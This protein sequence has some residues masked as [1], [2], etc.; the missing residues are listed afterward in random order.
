MSCSEELASNG[1]IFTIFY[2]ASARDATQIASEKIEIPNTGVSSD[3]QFSLSL[4]DLTM[5]LSL[6]HPALVPVLQ[7]SLYAVNMEY[8]DKEDKAFRVKPGDEVAVIP[9]VSGG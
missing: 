5:L 8:V 9:P 2:F 1:A 7:G 6:R 4:K 3:V